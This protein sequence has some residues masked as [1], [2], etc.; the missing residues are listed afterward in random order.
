M[1]NCEPDKTK[2]VQCGSRGLGF[3]GDGNLGQQIQLQ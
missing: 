2:Y 1:S 3:G